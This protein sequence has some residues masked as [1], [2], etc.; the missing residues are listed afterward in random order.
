MNIGKI[1]I[2][3]SIIWIFSELLLAIVKRNKS[4]KFDQSTLKLLWFTIIISIII[5]VFLGIRGIGLIR[6]CGYWIS[7]SGLI[8]IIFGVVIRW[9]SIFTLN[10]YFTVNI[11]IERDQQIIDSGFYRYIRHPAYLGS[12]LSFL[13]LGLTFSNWLSTVVIFIPIAISFGH[14]IR[15]EEKAMRD[16][17]GD[18]YLEYSKRTKRLLPFVY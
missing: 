6:F 1:L 12:L 4:S 3:V 7:L 17:L 15:C 14:R 18:K 13:G 2:T 11:S 16:N 10:K 5:G 9:I 8:L